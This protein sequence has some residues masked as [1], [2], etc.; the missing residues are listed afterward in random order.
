L[1]K[2]TIQRL[3]IRRR[4]GGYGPVKLES[5]YNAAIVGLSKYNKEGKD[6]LTRLVQRY[7]AQEAK[8]SLQKEANLRK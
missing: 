3:Y 1:N 2:S 5:A 7:D 6:R 4:N 8:Y